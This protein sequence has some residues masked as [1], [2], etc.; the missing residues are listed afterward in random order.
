MSSKWDLNPQPSPWQGDDLPIDLLL[1]LVDHEEIESSQN[2]CKGFSP[3]LEHD[4]PYF[5]VYLGLE[6]RTLTI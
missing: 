6:P 5:V 3:A 2:P 4:S 1:L